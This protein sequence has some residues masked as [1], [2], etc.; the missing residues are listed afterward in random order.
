MGSQRV[1]H[2]PVTFT[3]HMRVGKIPSLQKGREISPLLWGPQTLNYLHGQFLLE[4]CNH[5]WNRWGKVGDNPVC[6]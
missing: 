6:M 5:F 3:L 2:D 4:I 1:R